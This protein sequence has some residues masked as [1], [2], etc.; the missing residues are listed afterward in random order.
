MYIA[1][2]SGESLL[3][4]N[5]PFTLILRRFE[6]VFWCLEW[7]CC[8]F[9]RLMKIPSNLPILYYGFKLR[10]NIFLS[11]FPPP[12][13]VVSGDESM[14]EGSDVDVSR[15]A[16]DLLQACASLRKLAGW[17]VFAVS[18]HWK[19]DWERKNF[20]IWIIYVCVYN[21]RV[22]WQRFSLWYGYSFTKLSWVESFVWWEYMHIA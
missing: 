1:P 6:V 17:D 13:D 3:N 5:V 19:L 21:D 16:Q 20:Q 4:L 8:T 7:E 18:L 12:C 9:K 11:V 14:E 10:L 2:S 15:E 22:I